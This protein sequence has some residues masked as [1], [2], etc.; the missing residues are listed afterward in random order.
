MYGFVDA[1]FINGTC[2]F[3]GFSTDYQFSLI[4][5]TCQFTGFSADYQLILIARLQ[6]FR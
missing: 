5:I 2:Q 4:N 6:N 3:T 1:Q